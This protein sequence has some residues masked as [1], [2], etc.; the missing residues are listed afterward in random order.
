MSPTDVVNGT[1]VSSETSSGE[2]D[3]GET[4]PDKEA[5]PTSRIS[6]KSDINLRTLKDGV[7]EYLAVLP[8][9]SE[10][11]VRQDV[12]PVNYQYRKDDGSL[13]FS[14]TG[15]YPNIQI[16]LSSLPDS[17]IFR[18]NS[19]AT[20]LYVSATI[21]GDLTSGPTFPALKP[22]PSGSGYNA[23]FNGAGKPIKAYTNSVKKRFPKSL[24]KAIGLTSL[25]TAEQTKWTRIMAEL[26]KV[27]DRTQTSD[28][29][30]LIID[31]KKAVQYSIDFEQKGT[32]QTVGAWSIAVE[33]TA[34]RH[35][36]SNVPCAEFM[37]EIL[38][39]AYQRAGY[40][41]LQDFNQ[42][43]GN[44]LSYDGGSA[45]VTNFSAYLEKGGWIPWDPQVYIPP[46]GAFIMHT[47]GISPGH[48]YMSAGDNGRFIVDNGTPQ[49]RDLRATS[50]NTI[51]LMYQHGVFFLP[52]GFVPKKW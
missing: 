22:N 42:N 30:L 33:G 48:T 31:R 24:N 1:N 10:I 34:S 8:A 28:R 52:P 2:S 45:L 18:L 40:S 25:P 9:N 26:Q 38:R 39:Q 6:T 27:G 15:F 49:G 36:F 5:N 50:Q 7:L 44:V 19:I 35:G 17:E 12:Q 43:K 37:S 16:S 20:G 23:Y 11:L 14:S 29:A 4:T 3:L 41:H 21:S 47:N 13:A 51:D 46:A 32:V